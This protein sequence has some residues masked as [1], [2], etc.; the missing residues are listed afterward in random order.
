MTTISSD[1]TSSTITTTIMK[2][3]A[4][5]LTTRSSTINFSTFPSTAMVTSTVS[6][7]ISTSSVPITLI[8]QTS[9]H[10]VIH[11]DGSIDTVYECYQCFDGVAGKYLWGSTCKAKKLLSTTTL[12]GKCGL[13][14]SCVTSNIGECPYNE[15]CPESTSGILLLS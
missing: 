3:T 13:E 9:T 6:A 10:I 15:Y 12:N 1:A 8:A 2:T 14:Y 5:L 4:S 11:C 7:T